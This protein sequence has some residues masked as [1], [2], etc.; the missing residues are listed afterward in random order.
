MAESFTL[1]NMVPQNPANNRHLWAH[2][3]EAV[4]RIGLRATGTYVVTGPLFNGGKINDN[5]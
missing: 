2:I 1:A 4:R 3:E 5:R